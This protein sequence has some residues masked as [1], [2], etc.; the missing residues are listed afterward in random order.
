MLRSVGMTPK[1]FNKMVYYESIFYGM[2]ALAYGVPVS[3]L[4][5]YLI[6]RAQINTFEAPF[7]LPWGDILFVTVII[8]LIVGSSMVYA[9]SKV[10]SD[11][12]IDRLKQENN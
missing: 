12:I 2:K 7:T 10:K 6:Y 9:I 8:F 3:V 1:G 4:I 11:N 5:M